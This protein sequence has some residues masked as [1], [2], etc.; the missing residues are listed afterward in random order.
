MVAVVTVQTRPTVYKTRRQSMSENLTGPEI[1]D[2]YDAIED[3]HS[4][5]AKALR[6]LMD[7]AGCKDANSV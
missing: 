1:Q 3:N 4:A 2:I 6:R 7:R 5:G